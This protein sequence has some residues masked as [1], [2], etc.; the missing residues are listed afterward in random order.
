MMLTAE[1]GP[2]EIAKELAPFDIGQFGSVPNHDIVRRIGVGASCMVFEAE[3][4]LLGDRVAVKICL[5]LAMQKYQHIFLTEARNARSWC[6]QHLM[7]TYDVGTTS[8]GLP[9]VTM[10]LATCALSDHLK[11]NSTTL[12]S[13]MKILESVGNGLQYLHARNLVHCDVKP[14]NVL[15]VETPT[16]STW[17]LSDYGLVTS[18]KDP[19]R[20]GA[21]SFGFSAP[22]QLGSGRP[23]PATDVYSLAVLSRLVLD[24]TNL[25]QKSAVA[26][27]A[28]LDKGQ[29][30]NAIDRTPTVHDFVRAL[31]LALAA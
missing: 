1:I 23:T 31:S 2:L 13:G 8:T 29:A 20:W 10:R 16:E 30:P 28:V 4:R 7:Q 3:H 17:C 25:T 18:P 22:E 6:H 26:V 5:P 12:S 15:L 19:V 27:R 11:S 24:I 9:Y 21:G 14:T